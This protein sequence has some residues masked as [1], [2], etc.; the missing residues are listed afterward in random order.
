MSRRRFD[1]RSF[2]A[3]KGSGR[4]RRPGLDQAVQGADLDEDLHCLPGLPRREVHLARRAE[5]AVL[6][7]GGRLLEDEALRNRLLGSLRA[8][9]GG[10]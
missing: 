6:L 1:V 5:V 7:G 8:R 9:R 2:S 4:S 3:T 10:A